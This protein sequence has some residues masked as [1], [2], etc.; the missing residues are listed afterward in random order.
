[1]RRMIGK[2]LNCYGIPATVAGKTVR[3]FFQPSL[4]KSW[5][6][7]EPIVGPLGQIPGGQ[8]LYIGP[9]ELEITAGA[10]VTVAGKSYIFRRC[11]AYRDGSGPVYWWG[12]CVGKGGEDTWGSQA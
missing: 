2:I 11:E 5:Q 7:S 12:L 8:Y 3:I 4:S 10:Q 1:M 6:S 9:A